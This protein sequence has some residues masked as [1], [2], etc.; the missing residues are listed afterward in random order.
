MINKG[1][2]IPFIHAFRTCEGK[3]FYDVNKNEIV[4]ISEEIFEILDKCEQTNALD[5]R[6][7]SN[8]EI[9]SLINRGYL[10]SEKVMV[11]K[12]PDLDY[13]QVFLQNHLDTLLL[14]VSQGCNHR[15][16]YCIYSGEYNNRTHQN[17][18]MS[19]DTAKRTI[20]FI[21]ERSADCK[22]LYFG[23][24]GG[25]PLCNFSLIKRCIEYIKRECTGKALYLNIA[26]IIEQLI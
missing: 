11:S 1:K 2:N 17:K 21:V 26:L 6:F 8:I 12:H 10:I 15:C 22:T 14:Q 19:W 7:Y 16:E 18:I 5:D 9:K 3:Y 13:I 24:S 20:D 25:E 23:F 4:E